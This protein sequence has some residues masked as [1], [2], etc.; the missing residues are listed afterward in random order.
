[1]VERTS[2]LAAFTAQA[3]PM[4]YDHNRA[5]FCATARVGNFA[6]GLQH[7]LTGEN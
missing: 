4:S 1:M 5:I 6:N 2:G 3:N 7:E